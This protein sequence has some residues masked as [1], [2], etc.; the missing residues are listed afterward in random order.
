MHSI[1]A[2]TLLENSPRKWARWCTHACRGNKHPPISLEAE[3]TTIVE[4]TEVVSVSLPQVKG[5]GVG[6]VIDAEG[7]IQKVRRARQRVCALN[8]C[9]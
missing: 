7:V 3:R 5:G 1:A 9:S 6:L 2:W 8:L 4:P